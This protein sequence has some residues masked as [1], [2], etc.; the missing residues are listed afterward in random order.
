MK[1]N[2]DNFE[3]NRE[4]LYE[5]IVE[6]KNMD[7]GG[8]KITKEE[9]DIIQK[10]PN[11]KSLRISG[12][13]QETFEYFISK[14]GNQFE[15]IS[16]FKNKLVSDLDMLGTLNKLKYVYYFFNQRVTKL[17]D[18]SNNEKLQ[19]LAIYDFSWLHSIEQIAT[20][21]N[22]TYFA[23]GDEVWARTSLESLEPLVNSSVKHFAWWG[24]CIQ[25]NNFL[26]LSKSQIR[27]LDLDIS[28]FKM[29][30]LA[31]LVASIPELKGLVTKPYR[32]RGISEAGKTTTYYFLCKGKRMLEK[33][34]DDIKLEKYVLE[35]EE[36]VEM[37]R[38]DI[39]SRET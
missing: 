28:R 37:Y 8:G 30:D 1:I 27:E 29:D 22:L 32:E 35:F 6:P 39:Q 13:N 36:M 4:E 19:G 9:I 5:L 2:L 25:D 14:Y 26:C 20:A 21:S 34:K 16:F 12:L 31:Q 10:Y 11:A 33:G 15:A 7:V 18:M 17:W 24:K 3:K 38:E 23:I